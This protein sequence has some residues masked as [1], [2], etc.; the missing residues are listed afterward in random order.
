MPDK[1]PKRILI[2]ACEILYRELSALAARSPRIVDVWYLPKGLHEIETPK[3]RERIQAEI[4]RADP[5]KYEF[6]A[7]AYGLCN[8]GTLDLEARA[9]PLVIPRAH[10]CITFFFGS[11]RRYREYFDANPGTYY[12]TTGWAERGSSDS[13]DGIMSQLGLT[14]TYA[15]YVDKYGRENADYIMRVLGGWRENYKKL[16]YVRMPIE[17]LP[18]YSRRARAEAA[19]NGWKFEEVKGDTA[20][21]EALTTGRW[22]N[23]EF[24]V[25]PPGRKLSGA[26]GDDVFSVARAKVR[27]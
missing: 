16:T 13:A 22:D 6:V 4:D 11:R 25:V 24:V 3:M 5:A 17:G 20:I 18:D 14:S 21:L 15:E 23:G 2:I 26:H 27:K 10:D 1:A 9:I 12:R 7:L 19:E 8:N